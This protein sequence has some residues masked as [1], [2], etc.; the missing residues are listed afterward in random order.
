MDSIKIESFSKL[1]KPVALSYCDYIASLI[2]GCLP[3]VDHQD[4]LESVG[5][6]KRD[7]DPEYGYM[8]STKKTIQ[9]T[10]RYGKK[11]TITVEESA[12]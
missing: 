8:V 3:G 6:P 10:D 9:V 12:E 1:L 7:L 4:L 5:L 11:Y 2:S